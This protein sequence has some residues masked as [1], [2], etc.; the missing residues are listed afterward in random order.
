MTQAKR[1]RLLWLKSLAIELGLPVIK[2]SMNC[3][4]IKKHG[5]QFSYDRKFV[6]VLVYSHCVHSRVCPCGINYLT[7]CS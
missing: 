7:V 4:S 6:S 3:E 5:N 2:V 1:V